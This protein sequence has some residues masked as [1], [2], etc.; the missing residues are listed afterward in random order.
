MK[1]HWNLLNL[2]LIIRIKLIPFKLYLINTII[3]KTAYNSILWMWCNAN[4]CY[5]I[6][7]NFCNLSKRNF[8]CLFKWRFFVICGFINDNSC[9]FGTYNEPFGIDRDAFYSPGVFVNV[10]G[11]IFK[12]LHEFGIFIAENNLAIGSTNNQII[13]TRKPYVACIILR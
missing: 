8:I 6:V 3:R 12:Y 13:V 9:I 2:V 4:S 11:G 10:E 1:P 5:I 7:L